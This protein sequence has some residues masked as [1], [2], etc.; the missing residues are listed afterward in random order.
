VGVARPTRG[1]LRRR[2]WGRRRSWL[3]LHLH[4]REPVAGS[5]G[6]GGS[7]RH[8]CSNRKHANSAL[9]LSRQPGAPRAA[10]WRTSSNRRGATKPSCSTTSR[11]SCSSAPT[12]A[13]SATRSPL[14]RPPCRHCSPGLPSALPEPHRPSRHHPANRLPVCHA[15]LPHNPCSPLPWRARSLGQGSWE[16]LSE[17][18][19]DQSV[20]C[21]AFP[22][23][24]ICCGGCAAQMQVPSGGPTASLPVAPPPAVPAP[25]GH[26]LSMPALQLPSRAAAP[27]LPG[28]ATA[29][30]A[31]PTINP[32]TPLWFQKL[33]RAKQRQMVWPPLPHVLARRSDGRK[34][35]CRRRRGKGLRVHTNIAGY[36]FELAR[37]ALAS[38]LLAWWP[39]FVLPTAPRSPSIHLVCAQLIM[40][41]CDMLPPGTAPGNA[42]PPT[43]VP[44]LLE[45][46]R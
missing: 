27:V 34:D 1:T 4:L 26:S 44:G 17:A 40:R 33:Q 46:R 43:N 42:P 5:G 16:D 7:S 22:R 23:A 3:G 6:G 21:S 19:S 18:E 41:P 14:S 24:L 15:S 30:P 10:R 36:L 38:T 45:V 39:Q 8:S 37:A 20:V 28:D 35:D 32:S 2:Q 9:P 29:A 31:E 12:S 13:P 25:M 11:H